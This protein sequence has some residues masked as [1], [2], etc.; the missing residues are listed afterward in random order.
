MSVSRGS[1]A[2]DSAGF[3]SFYLRLTVYA[4][5]LRRV[6]L[7]LVESFDVNLGCVC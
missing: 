6:D 2:A 7:V 4:A 1:I 3:L 5:F